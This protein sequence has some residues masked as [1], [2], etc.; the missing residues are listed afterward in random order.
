MINNFFFS[1]GYASQHIE[2]AFLRNAIL[3]SDGKYY[4]NQQP[5]RPGSSSSQPDYTQVSP[6]KM[7]LRRHLSQEKLSQHPSSHVATTK[8][9]GDLVNGEIERTLEISNQ[10][11]I[12]AAI[13]MST[14]SGVP[15]SPT[16][17]PAPTVINTNAQRPERVSVRI[18]EDG[19][20]YPIPQIPDVK[21]H[22]HGQSSL[23][24]LAHVAF[25]HKSYS[26]TT[27]TPAVNN[28]RKTIQI[29]PRSSQ[30]YST[31]PTYAP[32]SRSGSQSQYHNSSDTYHPLPK[33]EVKPYLESYFTEEQKPLTQNVQQ[34]QQQLP[35]ERMVR[36]NGNH[37]PLEGMCFFFSFFFLLFLSV[38]L[39]S[40]F[41]T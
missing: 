9:I 34:Q 28:S 14:I 6:A 33:T 19:T 37:P 21:V 26:Q 20:T 23:A 40:D 32:Q 3:S 25:N 38:H 11:L 18:L 2:E 16:P 35:D 41:W 27:A 7:A 12:N 1:L 29:S 8:T 13:N 10:S 15:P 36:I 4:S 31:I 39:L 24:T 30:Q 17:A 5:S 22:L